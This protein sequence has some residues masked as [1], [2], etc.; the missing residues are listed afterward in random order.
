[1]RK[2]AGRETR[3]G[4]TP[5]RSPSIVYRLASLRVIAALAAM[6]LAG[7]GSLTTRDTKPVAR[8]PDTA[9]S[10]G[11][12]ATPRAGGYYLDD[13]PGDNPPPDLDQIPDAVPKR[14]PLHRGSMRPYTVMGQNYTPMTAVQP[15]KARGIASWYGRRYHGQKTSSGE[16]YDMYG[17]TAAHAVLPIPSYV[18]VANLQTN[19]SVVV[20]VN[21]R[22]PFHSDRLI[23]LSYT[24]AY[25]LGVLGGGRALVEVESI[26]PD[27]GTPT[28]PT[29]AAAP[30]STAAPP[31]AAAVPSAAPPPA[32]P[33]ATPLTAETAAAAPRK[34]P[35][36]APIAKQE[37]FAATPVVAVTTEQKGVFLQ[38]GAFGSQDN[39]DNYL[40]RL[41]SQI[42]WLAPLLH[43][44]PKDGLFRVHSGPYAN[45]AEARA[46]ADRISQALGIR[47]MVLVR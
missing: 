3:G 13:G 18:R 9:P 23:D 30:T 35:I 43:V 31:V 33:I 44:Y 19:K 26:V 21:D 5:R 17:M 45:Q 16:I 40:A 34:E 47:A 27:A 11:K 39:A 14:E 1:M 29:L 38:L 22:G 42:D 4:N 41:R 12:P 32:A 20:R 8:A 10:P 6:T 15:Y 36:A 25:K 2:D 7:C 24:A 37:P 28:T 46:A